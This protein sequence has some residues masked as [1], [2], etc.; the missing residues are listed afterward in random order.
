MSTSDHLAVVPRGYKKIVDVCGLRWPRSMPV[1]AAAAYIGL[2][3]FR[4]RQEPELEKLIQTVFGAEVVDR[5]ELD[6]LMDRMTSDHRKSR[7]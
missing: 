2:T 5:F 4:F 3:E 6:E 7:K 1:V